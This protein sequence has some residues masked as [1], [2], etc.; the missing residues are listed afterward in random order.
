M[1]PRLAA[2]TFPGNVLEPQIIGLQLWP[3][4]L[5]FN[6]PREFRGEGWQFVFTSPQG[7]SMHTKLREL[8]QGFLM[9][10]DRVDEIFKWE[11]Q[12]MHGPNTGMKCK[13]PEKGQCQNLNNTAQLSGNPT[14]ISQLPPVCLANTGP[15][16]PVCLETSGIS[17]FH[18]KGVLTPLCAI[19]LIIPCWSHP[20]PSLCLNYHLE[21]LFYKPISSPLSWAIGPNI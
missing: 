16:C 1:V 13:I 3:S 18:N 19:L 11:G 6:S 10:W 5:E 8:S 20:C 17:A 7:G 4:E 2:A 12:N 15:F 14:L 9:G 21:R